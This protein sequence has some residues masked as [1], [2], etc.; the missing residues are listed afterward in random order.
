MKTTGKRILYIDSNV[1]NDKTLVSIIEQLNYELVVVNNAEKAIYEI[2]EKPM[3]LIICQ[4]RVN[5]YSGFEIYSLF[6]SRFHQKRIPFLLVSNSFQKNELILGE[7][8]GIDGFIFPPFETEEI[9]NIIAK[10]LHK[11]EAQKSY[12]EKNFRTVCEVMPFALF[13]IENRK[14]VDANECF[15]TLSKRNS[16]GNNDIFITDVFNFSKNGIE[17]KFYRLLNG[18]SKKASFQNI[19][20]VNADNSL[21]NVYFSHVDNASISFRIIGIA[22]PVQLEITAN[23]KTESIKEA[24]K[25]YNEKVKMINDVVF[26]A[27][28]LEVLNLSATGIPIKQIADQLGISVRTVEKHRSN[29]MRKSKTGNFLE[30]VFKAHKNNLLEFS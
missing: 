28:E 29:V 15:R 6:H 11:N 20:L 14:I 26:T 9:G 4:L 12:W 24:V 10:Q 3:N 18:L 5:G 13:V 1:E 2:F 30:A 23:K 17:S 25:K 19:S 7:E 21:F 27:R 8:L 16:L 22:I